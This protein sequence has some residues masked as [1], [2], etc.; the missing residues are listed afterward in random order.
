M[1][2][3]RASTCSRAA[4]SAASPSVS[5]R[6]SSLIS[7]VLSNMNENWVST[8]P[9]PTVAPGERALA[10]IVRDGIV[11]MPALSGYRAAAPYNVVFMTEA[12]FLVLAI[13]VA[14]PLGRFA[15]HKDAAG[16]RDL[17]GRDNRKNPVE[18]A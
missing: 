15:G 1:T 9:G 8:T 18:V 14:V 5:R 13:A 2:W 11:A 6:C 7:G 16:H 4:I 3:T 12:A 10:G 17:A